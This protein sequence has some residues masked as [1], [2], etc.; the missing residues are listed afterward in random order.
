MNPTTKKI[1][2]ALDFPTASE[3]IALAEILK[4]T[5]VKFKVGMEL[6]YSA[7]PVILEKIR[8]CGEIF[9]DLKLHDIPE[10]MARTATVLVRHGVWM[11]NVHASAGD[12]ALQLVAERVAET[13]LREALPKPLVIAVTV[14]TSLRDMRHL[15]SSLDVRSSVIH[16]G[17]MAYEAKL[18]GVVCSPHETIVIKKIDPKFICVTPGIRMPEDF[19]GDQVRTA[20]P[21]DALANGSDYLVIGR[22]INRA[23]DPL[24]ALDAVLSSL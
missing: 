13:V 23:E 18:D 12:K 3:A 11:F 5:G 8:T 22:P 10:T 14:L 16:M 6:F 17:R 9:L 4:N 19:S 2:V 15:G 1:I 20:T 7:G 24:K 21:K